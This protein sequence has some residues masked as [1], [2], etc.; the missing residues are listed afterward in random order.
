MVDDNVRHIGQWRD[1]SLER[2]ANN[3]YLWVSGLRQISRSTAMTSS[4]TLMHSFGISIGALLLMPVGQA[5]DVIQFDPDLGELPESVVV[6]DAGIVYASLSEKLAV[7]K[8]HLDGRVEELPITQAAL[9]EGALGALGIAVDGHGNLFVAVQGCGAAECSAANG[10]WRI[11]PHGRSFKIAGTEQIPFPNDVTLDGQGNLYVSDTAGGAIWII[12][13]FM[14][15][16]S[17]H[18]FGWPR[19]W[20]QDPQ[21][22][23]TG[24]FGAFGQPFPLGANGIA[25]SHVS[26]GKGEILVANTEQASVLAIAIDRH[27]RP[28]PIEVVAGG[29]CAESPIGGV[30][31]PRLLS[32]DGIAVDRYGD[33]FAVTVIR[34]GTAGLEP[35]SSLYHIKRRTGDVQLVHE[36]A[37]LN[38]AT[39]VATGRSSADAKTAWIANPGFLAPLL[40]LTPEPSVAR[41]ELENSWFAATTP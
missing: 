6:D 13:N 33:V 8:I 5:E 24:F 40:G 23:G 19:I 37:P 11:T 35:V 3:H 36:G 7:A 1:V 41:L 25:F 9:P 12:R 15:G 4:H 18:H 39:D 20:V 31:D 38:Q 27:T 2:R 17:Q 10:V 28:G 30:C 22:L 14:R 26:H 21:L 29:L 16:G 32:V 34:L